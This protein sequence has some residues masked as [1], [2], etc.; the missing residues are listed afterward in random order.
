MRNIPSVFPTQDTSSKIINEITNSW[1]LNV[2]Y[3]APLGYAVIIVAYR[4]VELQQI[5]W[6]IL[7]LLRRPR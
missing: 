4:L 5:S 2:P 6:A 7:N 3:L 1:E